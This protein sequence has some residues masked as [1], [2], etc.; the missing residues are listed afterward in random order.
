MH[1]VLESHVSALDV[2]AICSHVS[3]PALHHRKQT[4]REAWLFFLHGK[5]QVWQHRLADLLGHLRVLRNDVGGMLRKVPGLPESLSNGVGQLHVRMPESKASHLEGARDGDLQLQELIEAKD[6]LLVVYQLRL[7]HAD[8]PAT[9]DLYRRNR[10]R[11]AMRVPFAISLIR[12]IPIGARGAGGRVAH[13]LRFR[14][15]WHNLTNFGGVAGCLCEHQV[16]LGPK[17]DGWH[18]RRETA[19]SDDPWVPK[20]ILQTHALRRPHL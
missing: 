14:D 20:A 7:R 6:C 11:T 3:D 9:A 13:G 19:G 10:W 16:W 17:R 12:C 15:H 2:L 4:H 1:R 5:P 18:V 8:A